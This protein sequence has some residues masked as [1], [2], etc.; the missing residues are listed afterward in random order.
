MSM[1]VCL[2]WPMSMS[3]FEARIDRRSV[4]E[5]HGQVTQ[6]QVCHSGMG[7]ILHSILTGQ[8]LAYTHNGS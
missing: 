2:V 6:M 1:F 7:G 8:G 4:C 3:L 5:P